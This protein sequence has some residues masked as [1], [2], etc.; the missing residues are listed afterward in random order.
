MSKKKISENLVRAIEH[1]AYEMGQH[2]TNFIRESE[3]SRTL[4]E[5]LEESYSMSG[6]TLAM[7][8]IQH[9]THTAQAIGATDL[10]SRA[11]DLSEIY[12]HS[13]MKTNK[14]MEVYVAQVEDVKDIDT[15]HGLNIV[16][17]KK[18]QEILGKLGVKDKGNAV[19]FRDANTSEWED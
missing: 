3:H 9:A 11:K 7:L 5:I 16:D 6:F 15:K 17:E 1:V 2:M 18:A 4:T 14:D 8:S 12:L 13:A 10:E 19:V